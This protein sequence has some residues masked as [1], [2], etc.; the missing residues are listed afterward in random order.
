MNIDTLF[1]PCAGK[2]TRMGE[3]G[4]FLPKPL[5]PFFESTLLD[6]QIE[7]FK[8]LG[9]K[10]IIINTHHLYEQ[11]K[12]Y[13]DRVKIL[14][15][16]ELLGSGGSLHNIKKRF[17]ALKKILI[18]NPDIVFDLSKSQWTK[19]LTEANKDTV[20]NTLIGLSC[21]AGESYNELV[22]REGFFDGIQKAPERKYLTYSGI[23][24][25]DL[26]SFS[27]VAGESSFFKTIVNENL[28]K[29]VVMDLGQRNSYWDF[30]TLDLYTENILKI[31]KTKQGPFRDVLI[32]MGIVNSSETYLRKNVIQ[33][34]STVIYLNEDM[35]FKAVKGE[36]EVIHYRK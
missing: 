15:E 24:V 2:G 20:E 33:F 14:Y 3:F 36:G 35:T 27:Y 34:G 21:C 6:F 8:R 9:F 10:N 28:N 29:T 25:V 19:F 7:Y 31:L 11:F 17:P 26:R 23:G 5:W 30:G 22:V 1:I 32:T 4:K 13:N 16:P 12:K 18:S